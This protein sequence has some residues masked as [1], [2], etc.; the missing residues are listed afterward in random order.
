M[1]CQAVEALQRTL[2][3][4]TSAQDVHHL[5]FRT[6]MCLSAA[7]HAWRIVSIALVFELQRLKQKGLL[8]LVCDLR[9]AGLLSMHHG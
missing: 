6:G 5:P 2:C 8:P 4:A 9:K 7:G 3:I 1:P